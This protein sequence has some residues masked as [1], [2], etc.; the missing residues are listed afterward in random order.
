MIPNF[1]WQE[2]P[3]LPVIKQ[4]TSNEILFQ[5]ENG[6]VYYGHYHPNGYFYNDKKRAGDDELFFAKGVQCKENGFGHAK[7]KHQTVR[8]TYLNE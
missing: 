7:P 4:I 8:W 6:T 2:L 5:I 3:K 1:N